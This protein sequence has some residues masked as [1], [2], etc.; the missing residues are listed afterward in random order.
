MPNP[1]QSRWSSPLRLAVLAAALS[2]FFG[3]FTLPL[4]DRD[5][6]RFSRATIEMAERGDWIIPWFNGD[7]RFDKPPLTYWLMQGGYLLLGQGEAGARLHSVL[8]S[9]GIAALLWWWLKK[10]GQPQAGLLSALVW[11]TIMQ[12]QLH[13]R[14]AVAD[15]PL[16]FFLTLASIALYE[17]LQLPPAAKG[18]NWRLLLGASL[19]LAF[20]AKGPLAYLIPA[21]TLVFYR[22]LFRREQLPWKQLRPIQVLSLSIVPV[23]AWGLPALILTDGAYWKTGM[24]EHVIDR[25]FDSFNSRSI[26]PG[27]YF[28]TIFLSF[29]PWWSWAGAAVAEKGLRWRKD[30][31]HAFLASWALAPF[32]IFLF[33]K[34][35]LPHY[36]LPGFPALALLLGLTLNHGSLQHPFSRRFFWGVQIFWWILLAGLAVFF[37]VPAWPD[38]RLP[39]RNLFGWLVLCLALLSLLPLLW[40]M[41][42]TRSRR[43]LAPVILL[44][45][46]TFYL[47][48]HSLSKV[49]PAKDV[50][51]LLDPLPE[52][53]LLIAQGYTEPS[54]VFYTGRYWKME[55]SPGQFT[56]A[57][58]QSSRVLAVTQRKEYPLFEWLYSMWAGEDARATR[59]AHEDIELLRSSV[60]ASRRIQVEGFNP[61]RMSWAVIEVWIKND[62]DA[63]DRP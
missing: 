6:P 33:Y 24:G 1:S 31:F 42:G 36:T 41:G 62:G 25:G 13:G 7:Y 20:L 3:I 9:L 8:T 54:L 44:A 21:V 15:M 38:E 12:V 17:L 32:L 47:G 14:L 53:T 23:I 22:W 55:P 11:L 39:L 4:I 26:I 34:T 56:S 5:E 51:R 50:A 30:P 59:L 19:G 60:P 35:Q 27:Y 10:K 63:G 29:L 18:R 40:K 16:I 61:A 2:L 48:C 52:D 57:W 43:L 37:L 58:Q 28:L 46:I 45:G 49:C